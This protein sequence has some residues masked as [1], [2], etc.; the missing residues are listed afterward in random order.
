MKRAGQKT[1]MEELWKADLAAWMMD[2]S[3]MFEY[4]P[5]RIAFKSPLKTAPYHMLT[6]EDTMIWVSDDEP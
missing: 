3:W 1:F 5:T 2:L 6:C 4:A